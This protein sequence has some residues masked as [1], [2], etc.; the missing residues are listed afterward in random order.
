MYSELHKNL[1]I[2]FGDEKFTCTLP[3]CVFMLIAQKMH[4]KNRDTI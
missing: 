2:K 3:P 1:C 4:K